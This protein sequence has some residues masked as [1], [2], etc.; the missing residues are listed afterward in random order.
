MNEVTRHKF[1]MISCIAHLSAEDMLKEK[2]M[3]ALAPRET[4]NMANKTWSAQSWS[5]FLQFGIP[6]S[7]HR[8][9]SWRRAEDCSPQGLQAL[10]EH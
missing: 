4:K 6:T 3:L 9:T 7:S 8:L 5:M 1:L 10:V 2:D